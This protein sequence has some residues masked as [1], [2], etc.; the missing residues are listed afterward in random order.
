MGPDDEAEDGEMTAYRTA[1]RI[2]LPES[3]TK[4]RTPSSSPEVMMTAQ[5]VAREIS[6]REPSREPS[7]HTPRRTPSET[8]VSEPESPSAKTPTQNNC[9]PCD[10][11]TL[12][13]TR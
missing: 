1:R 5:P 4:G 2:P 8:R 13:I 10:M 12:W 7:V 11:P 3:P 6:P 9:E